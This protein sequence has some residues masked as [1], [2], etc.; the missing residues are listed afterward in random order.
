VLCAFRYRTVIYLCYQASGQL[1]ILVNTE[2]IEEFKARKVLNSQEK[3]NLMLIEE[4]KKYSVDSLDFKKTD[5][6]TTIYD[7]S[8]APVLW[9]VTVCEPYELK[10]YE[11][12][13]PVVGSVSYK[14][15]FKKE[16]AQKE[17]NHFRASG[18]DVE[19]RSVSAWSTLGWF[20]DPVLSSML[21]RKKGSICNLLFHE[22]FHATYYAKSSVDFNENIAS[23]I[24]HKATIQFL[25]SDTT[26]L[27]DYLFAYEDNL[28]YNRFILEQSERLKSEYSNI[29]NKPQRQL[30]KLRFLH[31]ITDSLK[32]R[33]PVRD[34][35]VYQSRKRRILADK[36]A[37]FVSFQQYDSMQDSLEKV[38]NNI[39]R[40]NLKKMVQD[41]KRDGS[42]Y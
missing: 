22:L 5:N 8:G 38:F 32:K 20:K 30:L 33:L 16:L 29:K 12:K 25:S 19:V 28:R 1:K 14:G 7:Q 6:F 26:A 37:Y 10:A 11:W 42:Y 9:V 13:F 39:Y 17:A 15:F 2:S 4:V 34:T 23:F 27:S 18:Y 31:A 35:A 40:G 24:A 36:N 41:L 3:E 21:K